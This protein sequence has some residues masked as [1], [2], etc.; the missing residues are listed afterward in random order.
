MVSSNN[1]ETKVRPL[2]VLEAGVEDN[3]EHKFPSLV[4][5]YFMELNSVRPEIKDETE[6]QK[7][8][9]MRIYLQTLCQEFLFRYKDEIKTKNSFEDAIEKHKLTERVLADRS[10]FINR[11]PKNGDDNEAETHEDVKLRERVFKE[12][13]DT[14]DHAW[15]AMHS[16]LYARDLHT[17]AKRV[18]YVDLFWNSEPGKIK[19]RE[20]GLD[21]DTIV[22]DRTK[23]PLLFGPAEQLNPLPAMLTLG[24][25]DLADAITEANEILSKIIGMYIELTPLVAKRMLL[26]LP[27]LAYD[28]V[29]KANSA[30]SSLHVHIEEGQ[31]YGL[32]S[33]NQ[34]SKYNRIPISG[35]KMRIKPT[36][37]M[38]RK[39]GAVEYKKGES[40]LMGAIERLKEFA[41]GLQGTE[42]K[43]RDLENIGKFIKILETLYGQFENFE[44]VNYVEFATKLNTMYVGEFFPNI[45][46]PIEF[47][48]EQEEGR[49]GSLFKYVKDMDKLMAFMVEHRFFDTARDLVARI[50]LKNPDGTFSKFARYRW[51]KDGQVFEVN[52]EDKMDYGAEIATANDGRYKTITLDE[53]RDADKFVAI[54]LKD[55]EYV[56]LGFGIMPEMI[57]LDD[58]VFY[59]AY[60]Y[61]SDASQRVTGSKPLY[62]AYN[63]VDPTKSGY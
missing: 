23:L 10:I 21:A 43:S 9:R 54:G 38:N 1:Q 60:K 29:S 26:C 59:Y 39:T 4:Q 12:I 45:K 16:G 34:L 61:L 11:V 32:V 14:L 13:F 40:S 30:S 55:L 57:V 63:P 48:D 31:V 42:R 6:K 56:M 37:T 51:D 36:F 35:L 62:F 27:T 7:I 24:N 47:I 8:N 22:R 46:M 53:I 3:I 33:D 15:R 2:R 50:A 28:Q 17:L 58:G 49:L 44:E 52:S 18:E 20:M 5:A 41:N 25:R 19:L